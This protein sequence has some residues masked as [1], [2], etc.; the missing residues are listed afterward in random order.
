MINRFFESLLEKY[1][2]YFESK[3][4]DKLKNLELAL[5][6]TLIIIFGLFMLIALMVNYSLK[7]S[8]EKVIELTVNKDTLAE[9]T[10]YWIQRDTASKSYFESIAY[11]VLHELTSYDYS[12]VENKC[13]Y[14]LE[15]VYPDKYEEVYEI[16]N[17]ESTFAIENRVY[18]E[19]AIKDWT[20]KQLDKSAVEVKAVG[21]LTRKV[22]GV[23]VVDH[24]RYV[25]RVTLKM[26]NGLPFIY[27]LELN[28]ADK[29]KD[30][31]ERQER[32]KE[33][34]NL[35]KKEYEG[36]KNEKPNEKNKN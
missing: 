28:Y 14:A 18:Q 31:Q 21:Y 17:K 23:V 24:K 36:I 4:V 12:T 25:S 10:K 19:F 16:L 20:Y 33:I 9:G 6:V 15:L 35:D 8:N 13:N 30:K 27:G 26:N 3:Y 32:I 29:E 7:A 34:D 11:G 1:K 5:K 2:S 22:G